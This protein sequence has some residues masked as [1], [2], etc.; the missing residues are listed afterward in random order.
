LVYLFIAFRIH[1]SLNEIYQGLT[2][3][4]I[5]DA[6]YLYLFAANIGA[7]IMPWMIFYQQSAIVDKKLKLRHINIARFETL[8]GAIITQ[9]IMISVLIVTAT[10]LGKTNPGVPL[11]TVQQISDAITPYLGINVGRILFSLG[12]LGAALIAIIVVSLAAA[13]GIGEIT[14]YKHS[15]EDHPTEAPWFYGVYLLVVISGASLVISGIHLVKLNVAIEV[16]NSLLLPIILS[17]LF[18]LARKVLPEQYRLKGFY[19]V[20]VGIIL[21]ITSAIGL[22][23]GIWGIF[24]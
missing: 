4:P 17:F 13:W 5:H 8:I 22:I 18:L 21:F 9:L 3:L 24:V 20:L 11:Q 1:P 15:L 2:N 14:G 12:M 23:A 10:T 19:A 6:N 7:V 16:M